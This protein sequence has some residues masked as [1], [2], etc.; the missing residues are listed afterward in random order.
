MVNLSY[1]S[2]K[3]SK[4]GGQVWLMDRRGGEGHKLTDIKGELKNM[5][6]RRIV[7]SWH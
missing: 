7:R 6:G 4:N 3:D 5:F 1:L 2:E